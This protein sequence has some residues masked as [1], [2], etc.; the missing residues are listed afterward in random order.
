MLMEHW[1]PLAMPRD[2]ALRSE[3]RARRKDCYAVPCAS[4]FREAVLELAARRGVNVGDLARSVLLLLPADAIAT[5]PDPGEPDPED[6]ETVVLKSGPGAGRP[7]RRKPRLQVRLPA[8]YR[9]QD[10]RRALGI[11]LALDRGALRL[12]LEDTRSPSVLERLHAAEEEIERLRAA[13]T[14]L[15]FAPLKEGVRTRADALYVLGFPPDSRPDAKTIKARFRMLATI[16]HPDGV[17]GDHV[18][19]S[20]LNAAMARLRKGGG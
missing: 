9:T 4:A 2:H 16:H 6:R 18:R 20:Q 17:Y 14:A 5:A 1:A 13:V 12:S 10:I 8:G 19:M 7:W 15:S 11:A 3:R